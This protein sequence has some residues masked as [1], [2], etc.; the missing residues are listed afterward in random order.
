MPLSNEANVLIRNSW[1]ST[2]DI[3]EILEK[4]EKGV[5]LYLL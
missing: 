5:P 1:R 2:K 4:T 3:D